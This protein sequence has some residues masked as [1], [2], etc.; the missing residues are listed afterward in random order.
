MHRN[1]IFNTIGVDTSVFRNTELIYSDR[2]GD[3]VQDMGFDG[4]LVEGHHKLLGKKDPHLLYNHPDNHRLKLFFRDYQLS[5]DIAF[6]FSRR[7]WDHYPLTANKFISWLESVPSNQNIITLGL[8]YETFG[9]HQ[10]LGSGIFKFLDGLLSGLAEN[11]K[12]RMVTP[13][14]ALDLMESSGPVHVPLPRSWADGER[15]LSP[16]L[17]NEM[18]RDA[19]D[20]LRHLEKK[21][22]ASGNPVTLDNWRNLQTSDHFYYMSTKKGSDGTVHDYFSPYR[23]PYDAFMNYMNVLNDFALS[24]SPLIPV[25]KT[26]YPAAAVAD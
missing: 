2:I 20:N 14:N 25:S 16:W 15:D 1:I 13:S 6:R 3:M 22:M 24:L 21:V 4:V 19:F 11:K 7:D 5:D 8:D 26:R 12:I 23:S 17:G 10:K 18:Q 9:E